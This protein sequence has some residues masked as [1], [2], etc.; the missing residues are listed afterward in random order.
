MGKVT[1]YMATWTTYG[2]WLQGS[3]R[4][5][6]KDGQIR[7]PLA[8]LKEA[9]KK[10]QAD[11][12]FILTQENRELVRKAIFE[13]AARLGQKIHAMAISTTHIHLVL[14][15]TDELIETA[16][17]R[18]KRAATKALRGIGV[19]GKVWTRGYD[20]RF[21]FDEK[22]LRQRINYVQRHNKEYTPCDTGG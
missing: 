18:Y 17:A 2:T 20:K 11:R 22:E 16:V 7:G 6:V 8:K 14:G 15:V 3:E 19:V 1:G 10:A 21:C 12:R 4:G 13:E 9:N 5:Y